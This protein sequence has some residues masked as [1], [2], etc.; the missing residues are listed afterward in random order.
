MLTSAI[1]L[2][3]IYFTRM[4]Q[5]WFH[6][7]AAV[8]WNF[9]IRFN[10]IF[11]HATNVQILENHSPSKSSDAP[12]KSQPEWTELQYNPILCRSFNQETLITFYASL[13]LSRFSELHKLA[14]NLASE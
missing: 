11:R 7:Q 9:K 14:R 2:P 4:D 13:P 6:F 3:V 5:Y 8:L 1:F 12:E 10:D